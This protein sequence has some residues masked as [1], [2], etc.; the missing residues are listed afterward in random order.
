MISHINI[1]SQLRQV[2]QLTRVG[3]TNTVLGILPFYHSM[4]PLKLSVTLTLT[5]SL[6]HWPGSPI[7]ST[8][9]YATRYGHHGKV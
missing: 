9:S 3:K 4:T 1:I 5:V 2:R 7:T 8:N 6:S